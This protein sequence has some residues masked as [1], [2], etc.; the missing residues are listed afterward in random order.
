MEFAVPLVVGI[1]IGVLLSIL[2]PWTRGIRKETGL[3]PE[4]EARAL[5]GEAPPAFEEPP[6]SPERHR[7]F[8]PGELRALENIGAEEPPRRRRRT[9]RRR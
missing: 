7:D 2:V 9:K 4:L 6:P 3:D 5:L 8:D 1:S